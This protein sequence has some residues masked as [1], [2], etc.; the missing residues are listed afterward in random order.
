MVHSLNLTPCVKNKKKKSTIQVPEYSDKPLSDYEMEQET[1]RKVDIPEDAP[2]TTLKRKSAKV[3][4]LERELK[5]LGYKPADVGQ[6]TATVDSEPPSVDSEI[7]PVDSGL[8]STG[9]PV[10]SSVDSKPTIVAADR[11]PSSEPKVLKGI[12]K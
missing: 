2:I 4:S 7:Q 9:T 5:R 10:D 11:V 1:E 8:E 12:L 3:P 6:I